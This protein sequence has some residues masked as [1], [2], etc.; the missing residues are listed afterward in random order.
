MVIDQFWV[1]GGGGSVLT[2][3]DTTAPPHASGE[4]RGWRPPRWEPSA[5]KELGYLSL[6]HISEPTRRS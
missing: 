4:G 2:P 5:H 1:R 6:I 3:R